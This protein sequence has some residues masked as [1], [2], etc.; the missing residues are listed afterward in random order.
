MLRP[1]QLLMPLSTLYPSCPFFKCFRSLHRTALHTLVIDWQ[2]LFDLHELNYPCSS[3]HS[4]GTW[5]PHCQ[6]SF[7]VS[8]LSPKSAYIFLSRHKGTSQYLPEYQAS[9][10]SPTQLMVSTSDLMSC[11]VIWLQMTIRRPG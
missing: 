8:V 9:S 10:V 3:F 1:G 7:N 5:T 11:S 2:G 6:V 4:F